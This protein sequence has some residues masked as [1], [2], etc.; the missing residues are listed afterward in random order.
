LPFARAFR[1]PAF[2]WL[3]V[4][5]VIVSASGAILMLT[6]DGSTAAG[7]T[8]VVAAFVLL[9]FSAV[10]PPLTAAPAT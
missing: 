8:G 2:R 10:G 9:I 3:S 5:L 4:A 6:S 1:L 7:W